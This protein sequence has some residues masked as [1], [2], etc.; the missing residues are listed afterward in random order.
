MSVT[1][2]RRSDLRLIPL[3]A[4]WG[5]L[6]ASCAGNEPAAPREEVV[7]HNN[8]GSARMSRQEWSEAEREFRAGLALAPDDAVL[9]NNAAVALLQQNRTDEAAALLDRAVRIAPDDPYVRTNLGLLAR[10]AGDFERAAEH[11]RAVVR[12][13]P[14][15][16][17]A[18]Y[19]LAGAL[20]RIGRTDEAEG[21]FRNA[22]RRNPTHVS[23][24]YGLGR[25]LV[26]T[27]RSDEGT[28]LIARS[29][30]IRARS[31]IDEAMGTQYG[32]QGRYAMV[33]SH[34]GGGLEAPGGF[35]VHLSEPEPAIAADGAPDGIAR[36]GFVGPRG[37]LVPV[38]F[39][40]LAIRSADGARASLGEDDVALAT[41]S[42]DLDGDGLVEAVVLYRS[43]RPPRSVHVAAVRAG[44]TGLEVGRLV[45]GSS[46]E[47]PSAD[48]LS[49]A[50]TIVDLDH[51]GD[52]DLAWC[53][54]STEA[55]R[56]RTAT[57]DGT[58]AFV[59]PPEERIPLA[60]PSAGPVHLAFSDLDDDRDIDLVVGRADGIRVYANQRDGRF[61]DVSDAFDLVRGPATAGPF[62]IADLD[63]DD[64]MDVVVAT[65]AGPSVL[66]GRGGRF[67]APVAIA[68]GAGAARGVRVIDLDDD[69]F[70]DV[71]LSGAGGGIRVVR[72]LGARGWADPVALGATGDAVVCAVQDVDA[73]GDLDLWLAGP[74][75]IARALSEG[76]PSRGWIEID[77]VGVR[78]NAFGIG[79]KVTV[80]AGGLRQKLEVVEPFPVHLGVGDRDPVDAVRILWPGGVLQDE[81]DLPARRS[82]EVVQL[83]RKGTSCPLLYAWRD[84]DWRFVTDF[85]GG[86]AIGYQY[87]PGRFSSEPDT[88]EYVRIEGGLDVVDGAARVRLNNQLEE[89]LWFDQ[90]ELIAVDHRAGV[91]V[92]PDER[93]M[94][95][96]PYPGFRLFASDD[97]RPPLGATYVEAERDVLD[98]LLAR[99]RRYVDG[100]ALLPYKGYAEPHTLELDFGRIP[101]DARAVVLLDGWIDYADSSAT[102]AAAHAGAA[103]LPP[104][105][106]VDDGRGGWR[107]IRDHLMGFPAGL[108]KTMAVDLTGRLVGG[109]ARVRIETSMRI[110]WDRARLMVGGEDEPLVVRRLA[111]RLAE[112]RFGGFPREIFP[113]GAPPNEYDP[114]T[115][116][117]TAP[118][119]T[120]AGAYTA[121][122]DVRDLLAAIDDRLV[123]TRNGD[124]IELAFDVPPPPEDGFARTWLLF[125]D[126]F[127]KDMDANSA[128]NAEVGPVP[129]H[130]MPAYPYGDGVAPPHP[131]EPAE[132]TRRVVDTGDGLPGAAP[133]GALDRDARRERGSR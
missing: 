17:A 70:L 120:H 117:A 80:L 75:G 22:L 125:A 8:R 119:K 13:D 96:P 76:S 95:G 2:G 102:V 59:V 38:A 78:D 68:P 92:Y 115:V 7:R 87:A 127:G 36:I 112:L 103:L 14:D 16:V 130:G 122:G 82:A 129:F 110:Y 79:A 53:W 128:A 113:D 24:L 27:G 111:P 66:A 15:D 41:A 9:L 100:F 108:P 10:A 107:P 34:P 4:L 90:V 85:L 21:A 101:A 57:N 63:K 133:I 131:P 3:L 39:A 114:A 61:V 11:F 56:C 52:V 106:A 45:A 55:A 23:S 44:E 54:T 19:N 74:D 32:E 73:D 18:Q 99:D 64:R 49:A 51:D 50:L 93:L 121:F 71:V 86:C 25:L 26:S 48:G 116:D 62:A 20:V 132:R 6:I 98:R 30:E 29:Q 77:P 97:V 31:G 40:G 89:V 69:G 58:G 37:G 65:P 46:R 67:A 124:E 47:F 81:L 60:E 12:V 105:L 118:W 42:G 5:A 35:D 88:D 43:E 94:P 126:G 28:A 84:A 91:E 123:T 72:G 104:R 109:R 33:E 83:D 1:N